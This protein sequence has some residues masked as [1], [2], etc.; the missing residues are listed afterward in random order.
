MNRRSFIAFGPIAFVLGLLGIKPTQAQSNIKIVPV[1]YNGLPTTEHTGFDGTYFAVEEL[2]KTRDS[3]DFLFKIY[4]RGAVSSP[5]DPNAKVYY[6][7]ASLP[8]LEAVGRGFE[9]TEKLNSF[10]KT[11]FDKWV[12]D[13][14]ERSFSHLPSTYNQV[15]VTERQF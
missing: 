10:I 3:L 11:H 5:I 4:E 13:Y 12:K 15:R 8:A 14:Y 1:L 2:A 6:W 9:S 7:I